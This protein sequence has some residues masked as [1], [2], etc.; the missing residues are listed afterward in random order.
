[1]PI[2]SYLL[3]E[4]NVKFNV[5]PPKHVFFANMSS[6]YSLFGHYWIYM[7][8]EAKKDKEDKEEFIVTP[9]KDGRVRTHSHRYTMRHA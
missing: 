6:L 4:I 2:L 9:A 8:M 5:N 7:A 1:M 3:G